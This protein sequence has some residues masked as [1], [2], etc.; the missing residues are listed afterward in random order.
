RYSTFQEE[1]IRVPVEPV[2]DKTEELPRGP[3]EERNDD[4]L[5]RHRGMRP[6]VDPA[7]GFMRDQLRGYDEKDQPR[8]FETVRLDGVRN[9]GGCEVHIYEAYWAY[10]SR[11]V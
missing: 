6:E 1:K 2:T 7:Q 9:E 5:R 4:A 11:R 10:L 3:F 8:V